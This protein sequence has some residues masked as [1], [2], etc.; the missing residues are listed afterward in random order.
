[1]QLIGSLRRV[2]VDLIQRIIA[3]ALAGMVENQPICQ[4]KNRK[5]QDY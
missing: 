3:A 5:G 1:M 2:T 4:A